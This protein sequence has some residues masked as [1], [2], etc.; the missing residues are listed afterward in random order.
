MTIGGW[1]ASKEVLAMMWEDEAARA[2]EGNAAV[3]GAWC[4]QKRNGEAA[5]TV[6]TALVERRSYCPRAGFLRFC[7]M[8]SYELYLGC[9]YLSR[10]LSRTAT[11]AVAVHL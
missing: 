7:G 2:A 4:A 1:R 10:A 3:P 11:A 9:L 5:M 8:R 6:V